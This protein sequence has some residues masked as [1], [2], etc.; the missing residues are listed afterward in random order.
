MTLRPLAA[1]ALMIAPSALMAQDVPPADAKPLSE[2]LA[3][4]EADLG[5]DLG[6]FDEV[7]WDDD[8]YYDIEYRTADNREVRVR[9]DP[10]TGEAI[11]R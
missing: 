10:V 6:H 11:Q 8:G 4:I 2:I 3:G 1:L 5:T 7:D 9:I